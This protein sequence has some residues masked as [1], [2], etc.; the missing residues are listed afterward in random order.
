MGFFDQF[1]NM[2]PEQNQG[3]LA[4]AAQLL[5]AGGPSRMPTSLGQAVGQGL[6]AYQQG[7]REA[8][9]YKLQQEQAAQAKLFNDLKLRD[10]QSDF[11]NQEAQRAEAK[12]L[13]EFQRNRTGA[14]G[15]TM[16]AASMGG[17]VFVK[18]AEAYGLPTDNDSLNQIVKGVNGGF[19]PSQA[20]AQIAGRS[21]PTNT[22]AEVLS[23]IE[24]SMPPQ[25]QIRRRQSIFEQKMAEAAELRANGFAAQADAL[26]DRA[27]KFQPKVKGW[28]K[29]QQGGTVMFAPYFEDGTS[30]QP[31]PLE[32][33]QQLE[34][35]DAGGSVEALNPFTGGTVRSIRKSQSP[36]SAASQSL[37]WA[38]FGL[39]KERLGLDRQIAAQ[40]A[41]VDKA[42]TEFQ[43]KS[44]AF[45]LRANEAD[46]ILRDLEG[47][48]VRN[49]GI[50]RSIAQ[51]TGEMVPFIGDRIGPAVGSAFNTLPGILGGPNEQQQQVEQARRDFVNA[52]LR[53]ESGAAIGQS[54]FENAARQYFPQPGDTDAVVAQ[55]AR[56]RALAIQGLQTNAGRA[57]MT[58]AEASTLPSGWSVEQN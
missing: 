55:K 30:G 3:L 13:Q 18:A 23:Q 56:N 4:A 57:R 1:R 29:V 6:Q 31:V 54:E 11:A 46:K 34:F 8:E 21:A 52:V 36:D 14:L 33:A 43:G 50:I 25:Q 58:A 32:V 16:P 20:A 48:G 53:Q 5:Q 49:T 42:P 15:A 47:K 40:K 45:G 9:Q 22:N 38:N 28:E 44:A 39:S 51:G 35:R 10:L 24:A 17:E 37:G 19:T 41:A 2:S 12:R 7:T 26:E 27:L